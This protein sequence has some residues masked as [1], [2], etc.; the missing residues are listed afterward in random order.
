MNHPLPSP[1]GRV[2]SHGV[3]AS[4]DA[5][6]RVHSRGVVTP[7]LG[8]KALGPPAPLAARGPQVN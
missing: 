7:P 1:V 3:A 5:V 8:R 6:G 4:L 2:P